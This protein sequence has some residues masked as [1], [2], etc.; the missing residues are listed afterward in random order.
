MVIATMKT[1]HGFLVSLVYYIGS[2]SHDHGFSFSLDKGVG[3][4]LEIICICGAVASTN[5]A[6]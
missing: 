6:R 3:G 5:L 4:M 2:I 1:G